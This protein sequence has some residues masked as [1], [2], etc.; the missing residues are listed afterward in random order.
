VIARISRGGQKSGV[1]LNYKNSGMFRI[2]EVQ[3]NVQANFLEHFVSGLSLDFTVAIDFSSSSVQLHKLQ[4]SL[5]WQ[6]LNKIGK[7]CFD[8]L[9]NEQ[10]FPIFAFGA[11]PPTS[12]TTKDLSTDLYPGCISLNQAIQPDF[13]GTLGAFE[14]AAATLQKQD[15]TNVADFISQIYKTTQKRTESDS[16]GDF[17]S[18]L[19]ILTGMTLDL[20]IKLDGKISDFEEACKIM[21]TASE[22]PLSVVFLG[23]G[24]SSTSFKQFADFNSDSPFEGSERSNVSFLEFREI[25]NLDF[26]QALLHRVPEQC[27]K[28]M[29]HNEITP[30]QID[31]S[32]EEKQAAMS[33]LAKYDIL[34]GDSD[35]ILKAL[36]SAKVQ[37]DEPN[38]MNIFTRMSTT[39]PPSKYTSPV[40]KQIDGGTNAAAKRRSVI[41]K[42]DNAIPLFKVWDEN[43]KPATI[44]ESPSPPA[45]RSNITPPD[46]PDGKPWMTADIGSGSDLSKSFRTKISSTM[47]AILAK[48]NKNDKGNKEIQKS[49]DD[50]V[51]TLGRIDR[52][53]KRIEDTMGMK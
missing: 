47:D 1:L 8:V 21:A 12:L 53:L 51:G 23:I 45:H 52:R 15:A 9:D 38:T 18:I 41:W 24:N 32:P 46:S 7:N 5:Y 28:Y 48:V 17:Y 42:L 4:E 37:A 6:A 19:I 40:R 14:E 3:V 27:L 49:L 33:L 50:I 20:L 36:A 34:F 30:R 11:L 13:N 39:A 25:K 26:S 43:E 31:S 10:E 29:D 16:Q 35:N 44:T 22:L 2:S